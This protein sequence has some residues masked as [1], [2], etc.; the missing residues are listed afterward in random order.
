VRPPLSPLLITGPTASGKSAYAI[1]RSAEQ[2]SVIINADSM[3]VYRELAI[4]TARPTAQEERQVPHRLFGHVPG[5]EPYSAGRYT[6]EVAAVLAEA[7]S[8][9]L[10]PIIVGGTGLYIRAL[11]QGLSP[12]PP[13]PEDVRSHWRREADRL[14]AANLHA[15]LA[16]Q[17]PEMASRLRPSDPQRV[18]RALEVQAAT[19]RS[20][21]EWQQQ[22]GVP[23]IDE[24]LAETVVMRPQREELLARA[25]ARFDAM[26]AA[27]ALQEVAALA[28][29]HLDPTLPV[30]RALGVPPLLRH[31]AGEVA[32]EVAVSEAKL[33][34]RQYIKRQL[35]WIKRNM[36]AWK[37][38]ET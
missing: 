4:I 35:T 22:P 37:Q 20:L 19:G 26:M 28:D 33:A 18:T 14:G 8:S 16:R 21:L 25:D 7:A 5:S 6:R 2:P 9:N 10:R 34:T 1:A 23:L 30:M 15:V 13:V 12:V 27:G 24:T 3:Q 36:S 32:R 17:D 31:W 29:L 11:L 38:L